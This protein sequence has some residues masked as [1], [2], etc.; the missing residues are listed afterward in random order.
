M[1]D[2]T[3]K[4]LT[5][6]FKNGATATFHQ[7]K[8]DTLS[9]GDFGSDGKVLAFYYYGQTVQTQRHAEFNEADIAGY[10]FDV[11]DSEDHKQLADEEKAFSTLLTGA[12]EAAGHIGMDLLNQLDTNRSHEEIEKIAADAGVKDPKNVE[13]LLNVAQKIK[14]IANHKKDEEPQN[15]PEQEQYVQDSVQDSVQ[16]QPEQDKYEPDAAEEQPEH[17]DPKPAQNV[18]KE[19]ALADEDPT[20]VDS[21]PVDK[22]SK[23]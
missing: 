9:S 2:L 22:E 3:S 12:A 4:N 15:T 18:P 17:V 19:Q 21:I 1:R 20:P 7:V 10:A 16:E 8:Y 6:W 5:I 14:D 13:I 23:N 11:E